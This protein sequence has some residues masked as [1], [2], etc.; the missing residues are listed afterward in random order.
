[1]S[2]E[3][4]QELA[5]SLLPFPGDPF[6]PPPHVQN[7]PPNEDAKAR[8]RYLSA[9]RIRSCTFHVAVISAASQD[10]VVSSS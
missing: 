7:L 6:V 10:K 8:E 4:C 1:M 2:Q 5:D 3:L 9:V